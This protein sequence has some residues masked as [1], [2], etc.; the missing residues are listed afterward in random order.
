MAVGAVGVMAL[1]HHP[2]DLAAAAVV[3]RAT[4]LG[5]Q[6]L[7]GK[8][9]RVEMAKWIIMAAAGAVQVVRASRPRA[10]PRIVEV[11]VSA[12][13]MPRI[14]IRGMEEVAAVAG[15]TMEEVYLGA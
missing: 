11:L 8:V 15:S 12:V 10:F 7:L 13:V 6:G 3:V 1:R 4:I 14:R 5:S 2:A 9:L